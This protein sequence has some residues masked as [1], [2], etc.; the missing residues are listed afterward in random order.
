MTYRPTNVTLRAR[1]D[2]F[3]VGFVR[4]LPSAVVMHYM[5]VHCTAGIV[6]TGRFPWRNF[7]SDKKKTKINIRVHS[8]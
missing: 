7:E 8:S 1:R 2:I 4:E 3:H 5:T 6:T